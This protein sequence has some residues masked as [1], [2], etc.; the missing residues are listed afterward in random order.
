MKRTIILNL[1][2]ILQ[3]NQMKTLQSF[4]KLLN[5]ENPKS[6]FPALGALL[7]GKAFNDK[8]VELKT[9]NCSQTQFVEFMIEQLKLIS[10][11]EI[12]AEQFVACWNTMNNTLDEFKTRLEE[13]FSLKNE[14]HLVVFVS[15]TNPLDIAHFTE[16]LSQGGIPFET[17]PEGSLKSV[18]GIKILLS[19]VEKKC[20]DEMLLDEFKAFK[21]TQHSPTFLP[22]ETTD[23]VYVTKA[24]SNSQATSDNEKAS[25][26]QQ[27]LEDKRI[28]SIVWPKDKT[29]AEVIEFNPE[30]LSLEI[31]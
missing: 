7:Q 24:M 11:K 2:D 1:G 29:L 3:Q 13:V 8:L 20:R 25:A 15:Y 10:D 17:T 14:G 4:A 16:Q 5:P 31:K 27:A 22:P 19:Y 12:T 28:P 18:N 23:W 30:A 6:M 26:E 9:G 21:Q